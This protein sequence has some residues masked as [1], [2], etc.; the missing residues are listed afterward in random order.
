[1]CPGRYGDDLLQWHYAEKGCRQLVLLGAGVDARAFRIEGVPDLKVFEVDQ[2]T[3]FDFKEPIVQG[4]PL[5]VHSR[6]IV[7]TDFSTIDDEEHW[8]RAL[9]DQGF[10]RSVPTVWLLEGLLMYLTD[11]ETRRVMRCIGRLSAKNSVVFHDAITQS[12]VA[13]GI[14]VAGAK[15]VGGSDDYGSMWGYEAGFWRTYVRNFDSIWVDRRQRSLWMDNRSWAEATPQRCWGQKFTL[16]V[17]SEKM[18]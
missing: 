8:E 6:T 15:F 4:R 5:T 11:A 7:A 12:Q 13:S 1:M 9:L 10:D 2:P 14:E 16:F 18:E 17:Q 3:T